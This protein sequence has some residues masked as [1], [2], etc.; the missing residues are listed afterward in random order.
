MYFLLFTLGKTCLLLVCL[1][2]F[3]LSCS[4]P[5]LDQSKKKFLFLSARLNT[6]PSISVCIALNHIRRRLRALGQIKK[7]RQ[8]QLFGHLSAEKT[9]VCL[10]L[11]LLKQRRS[12]SNLRFGPNRFSCTSAQPLSSST[13][14]TSG[15]TRLPYPASVTR[16]GRCSTRSRP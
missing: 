13:A 3:G 4:V 1:E 8:N 11:T 2:L 14:Q 12:A 6:F 16:P 15:R 7:E 10:L 5:K 9:H